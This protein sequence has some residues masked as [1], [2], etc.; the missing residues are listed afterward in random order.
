MTM[1]KEIG[2]HF[3]RLNKIVA[4]VPK[5]SLKLLTL[6]LSADMSTQQISVF[7]D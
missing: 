1:H 2:S 4:E 5:D 6:T 7:L 3:G